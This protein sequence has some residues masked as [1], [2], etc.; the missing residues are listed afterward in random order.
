MH[1]QVEI[2]C[3]I[4]LTILIQQSIVFLCKSHVRIQTFLLDLT[5]LTMWEDFRMR[6]PLFNRIFLLFDPCF[7]LQIF[8]RHVLK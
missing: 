3:A 6:Q 8:I 5:T 2:H 4:N 7:S 1:G